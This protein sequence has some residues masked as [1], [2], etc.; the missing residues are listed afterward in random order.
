MRVLQPPRLSSTSTGSK[1]VTSQKSQCG[2]GVSSREADYHRILDIL[3][4]RIEVDMDL[5]AFLVLLTFS[6]S[7][8]LWMKLPPR[9]ILDTFRLEP[10]TIFECYKAGVV[11]KNPFRDIILTVM[12]H[13]LRFIFRLH[14]HGQLLADPVYR[15]RPAEA[16]RAVL[17]HV[18]DTGQD[19]D[20]TLTIQSGGS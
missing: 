6:R 18:A 10:S 20:G 9:C 3:L 19:G 1:L 12:L 5:W 4:H 8:K 17:K 15:S 16:L 11:M 2:L 13:Q 7:I 14:V